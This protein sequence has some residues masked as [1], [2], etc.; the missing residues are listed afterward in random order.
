MRSPDNIAGLVAGFAQILVD[1]LDSPEQTAI[2]RIARVVLDRSNHAGHA[3][4]DSGFPIVLGCHHLV[5]DC[6]LLALAA[7][8]DDESGMLTL[9]VELQ[10]KVTIQR[11][12]TELES[13]RPVLAIDR[14]DHGIPNR[15]VDRH[16]LA[17]RLS[18]LRTRRFASLAS[19]LSSIIWKRPSDSG[20]RPLRMRHALSTIGLLTPC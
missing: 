18:I 7:T 14:R 8:V 16:A 15:I 12:L 11:Q 2:A 4:S 1:R 17:S 13:A 3:V 19:P 20:R 9:R 5:A 6:E 10:G